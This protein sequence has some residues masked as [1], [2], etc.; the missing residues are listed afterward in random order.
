[1]TEGQLKEL[2]AREQN[3]QTELAELESNRDQLTGGDR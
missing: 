2:A 3:L 1:M